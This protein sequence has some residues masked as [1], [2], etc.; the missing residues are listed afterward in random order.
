MRPAWLPAG[1]QPPPPA[2]ARYTAAMA[3]TTI[4][5]DDVET[6]RDQALAE[7]VAQT[8]APEGN[9]DYY[10]RYLKQLTE[11]IDWCERQRDAAMP[12]EES[13][14]AFTTRGL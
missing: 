4:N 13:H 9:A 1:P 12:Y 10:G 14:G 2:T 11:L 3:G 7:L 6:V 8:A 5:L